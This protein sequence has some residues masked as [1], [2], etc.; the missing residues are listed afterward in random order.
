MERW[1][2]DKPAFI[3][4]AGCGQ[5]QLSLRMAELGH[6]VTA[7]DYMTSDLESAAALRR[8]S[9]ARWELIAGTLEELPLNHRRRFE[10]VVSIEVI[11]HLYR[12]VTTLKNLSRVMV[13]GG[14]IILST[15]YHGWLKNVAIS[16]AGGWDV[17]H[18]PLVEGGH[19][20][21]WSRRT[22]SAALSEAGF[23]PIKWRGVGRAPYLWKSIIVKARKL[24]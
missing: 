15:P 6:R 18:H 23:E 14:T 24:R 12:P 5:G 19:I 10:V 13:L 8:T 20:K 22:L 16:L 4:D 17:H 3:L 7:I 21:F 11:E 1:L 9:A 2:P